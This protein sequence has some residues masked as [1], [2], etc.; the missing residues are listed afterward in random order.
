MHTVRSGW[1]LK[2]CPREVE[3]LLAIPS[4]RRRPGRPQAPTLQV[5]K[6]ASRH[7]PVH[8]GRLGVSWRNV[9][10]RKSAH[11]A[12]GECLRPF[13]HNSRDKQIG[14]PCGQRLAH[15]SQRVA[16]LDRKVIRGQQ[17]WVAQMH[18]DHPGTRLH[19]CPRAE[20]RRFRIRG[21]RHNRPNDFAL[22]PH[23]I[24]ARSRGRCSRRLLP[25]RPSPQRQDQC[26]KNPQLPATHVSLF[27]GKFTRHFTNLTPLFA[28]YEPGD[29][30]NVARQ[31]ISS[32][33]ASEDFR[34]TQFFVPDIII[35]TSI[36]WRFD[37]L[38]SAPCG[39]ERPGW[40]QNIFL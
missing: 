24:F 10:N 36:L 4:H 29:L 13:L 33:L 28:N 23:V 8:R 9:R 5:G 2:N 30:K 38:K 26:A 17:P 7:T 34:L 21:I 25:E 27:S 16:S 18:V 39:G 40:R 31:E 15:N 37:K 3:A 32:I 22:P 11:R 19:R 14:V 35:C 12:Y 20:W 6:S 1:H